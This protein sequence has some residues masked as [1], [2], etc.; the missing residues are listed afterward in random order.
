[1]HKDSA[2]E[3]K[4]L[5]SE[6]GPLSAELKDAEPYC[7]KEGQKTLRDRLSKGEFRNLSP[8]V[9]QEG[10]WRVGGRADK[11][12]VSYEIRHHVL[13]PGDHRISRLITY[14]VWIS[15]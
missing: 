2:G 10:V 1:M 9:D 11:A 5:K 14:Y 15:V 6:D 7:L 3:G 4:P 12:L 13:L 8:Y